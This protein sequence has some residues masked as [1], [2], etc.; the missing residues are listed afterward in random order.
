VRR[1]V[2]H[3]SGKLSSREQ[4]ARDMVYLSALNER[5]SGGSCALRRYLNPKANLLRW[6]GI[7]AQ[8]LQQPEQQFQKQ[9]DVR[10]NRRSDCIADETAVRGIAEGKNGMNTGCANKAGVSGNVFL[11]PSICVLE[12]Q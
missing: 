10:E 3:A 9:L 11:Q 4:R 12:T 8:K 2:R 6:A 1:R 5:S 7:R